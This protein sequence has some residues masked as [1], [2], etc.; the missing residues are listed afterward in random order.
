[1]QHR[2]PAALRERFERGELNIEHFHFDKASC[3][4]VLSLREDFLPNLEGLKQGMRAIMKGRMRVQRLNGL[5]A[6][7]IVRR[8][9]PQLLAEG[10]AERIVEFVA[11]VRGGSSERML[12]M[13][14]EPA[15]LSV[16][17][18]ELNERRRALGQ[19]KITADLVSGNRRE[20]LNDFY[21]RSVADLPEPMRAFVEDRLL[22]KS[23][24]RDNLALETAL[25][26]PGVTRPLID[27]LVSRRL[28]RVED[29]L[30][31]ARVELTHDVLAEV[32]HASR[33]ARQQRTAQQEASRRARR[34]RVAIGSLAAAV[35]VVTIVA[36]VALRRQRASAERDRRHAAQRA[37]HTDQLLASNL[38]AEG[39]NAEGLAYLTRAA[40]R[41]PENNLLAP[42]IL[43]T[44]VSRNF[45]LPIDQPLLLPSPVLGNQLAI[46]SLND[47]RTVIVQSQ[48]RKI[49]A[50]DVPTWKIVR[51][52]KF[53]QPV[54]AE[55]WSVATHAPVLCLRFDDGSFQVF[56]AASGQARTGPFKPDGISR[57][58]RRRPLVSPDGCWVAVGDGRDAWIWDTA[59]GRQVAKLPSAGGQ[60]AFA[61]D[62]KSIMTSVPSDARTTRHQPR[63]WSLPSGAPMGP[64][65]PGSGAPFVWL[66]FVTA[67]TVAI[68][69]QTGVSV[70]DLASGAEN[71]KRLPQGQSFARGFT[72]DG[73]RMLLGRDTDVQVIDI[74]TGELA[75]PPLPHGGPVYGLTV[76]AKG[77]RLFT[78][79]VDG[80]AR[81]WDLQ[82]GRL[83]VEPILK[84]DPRAPATMTPDGKQLITFTAKGPVYRFQLDRGTAEPLF[85]R[86]EHR[87]DQT[88]FAEGSPHRL[89]RL[90]SGAGIAFDVTTGAETE[91][92]FANPASLASSSSSPVRAVFSPNQKLLVV[93]TLNREFPYQSWFR[94]D[95][96][97]VVRQVPLDGGRT[98]VL[99]R[100]PDVSLHP[101]GKFVALAAEGEA[102]ICDTE[103][104]RVTLTVE[105]AQAVRF[106]PDGGR[107][108]F[109]AV[110]GTLQVREFP[111]GKEIHALPYTGAAGLTSY[112][113]SLEGKRI[114]T[115]D[116]WGGVHFW[117]AADGSLIQAYDHHSSSARTEVFSPDRRL[118]ASLSTDGTAQIWDVA[119]ARPLGGRL[120]HGGAVAGA[121]FGPDGKR[122]VTMTRQ[123]QLRVWDVATGHLLAGPM[124]DTSSAGTTDVIVSPDGRFLFADFGAG[125]AHRVWPMPPTGDSGTPDWLLRLAT[126]AAGRRLTEEG[127]WIDASDELATIDRLRDEISKLPKTPYVE[128]AQWFLSNAPD[129]PIAPGFRITPA[130]VYRTT[131]ELNREQELNARADE[132]VR[133]EN[134][135]E[136]ATNSQELLGLYQR[137]GRPDAQTVGR[138]MFR[139]GFALWRQG[140]FSEAEP[141]VRECKRIWD[142]SSPG[143][144]GTEASHGLLGQILVAQG[145]FQ[146]AEPLLVSAFNN[147]KNFPATANPLGIRGNGAREIALA[148]ADMYTKTNRTAEAAEWTAIAQ[149]LR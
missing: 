55:G 105:N 31:V 2:V 13:E 36:V 140:R 121:N 34:M 98:T 11:G 84:Q 106:S 91:G 96:G 58:A 87:I 20:I 49:R 29:R 56:D 8:P 82:T 28:L 26:S 102:R 118:V 32:I 27:T 112:R 136:L 19:E 66:A 148:L 124:E 81:I 71:A 44:L 41:D 94:N 149:A 131:V 3:H 68:A 61:P 45:L 72:P 14:L 111:G 108:V 64:Q 4:I 95:Q 57:G 92:G 40:R 50:V 147:L 109:Q 9:A 126:V 39:K 97:A 76:F 51:E 110:D 22:T 75:F 115:A 101:S 146:E 54:T 143:S 69:T 144:V 104:G 100:I 116:F 88:V 17:C 33:D 52:F 123:G 130:E 53:D 35:V 79:C 78:N 132:L 43:S 120:V 142:T 134:W 5:Q 67:N 42:R 73:K 25:E 24:F 46:A 59:T 114:V 135:A 133:T 127:Q 138:V 80:F 15:L 62:S 10:V 90:L 18:R 137:R 139:L 30:G 38:L 1:M 6:L 83:A 89:L 16:I 141:V 86:R 37:S 65:L 23:G 107:F 12:E 99:T 117:N 21:E 125:R 70:Y 7:E 128:W 77:T 113:F 103:T 47:Q 119:T 63:L 122:L 48:D 93:R 74:A 145:R 60:H 129:R 85:L